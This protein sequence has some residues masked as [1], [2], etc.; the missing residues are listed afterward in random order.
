MKIKMLRKDSN[1]NIEVYY[2]DNPRDKKLQD[3][4]RM[5]E[6]RLG[7]MSIRDEEVDRK[8]DLKRRQELASEL[9][10]MKILKKTTKMEDD[11]K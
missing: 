1:G 9:R 11:V 7:K 3:T 6:R 4:V 5:K 8:F 2:V 10:E